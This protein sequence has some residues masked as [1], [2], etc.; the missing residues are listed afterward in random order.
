M[1]QPQRVSRK[2]LRVQTLRAHHLKIISALY[3][4][5]EECHSDESTDRGVPLPLMPSGGVGLT[6]KPHLP[7]SNRG[8]GSETLKFPPA[9][10]GPRNYIQC[11]AIAYDDNILYYFILYYATFPQQP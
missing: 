11:Y 6:V 4:N 10:R 3:L 2:A 1:A 9:V 8:L 7:L 5:N